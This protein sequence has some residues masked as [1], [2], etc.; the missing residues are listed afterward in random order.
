[1]DT[2]KKPRFQ[3]LAADLLETHMT[4]RRIPPDYSS[5]E[6]PLS[7]SVP[8]GKDVTIRAPE[9]GLPQGDGA[10]LQILKSMG[11]GPG[12]VGGGSVTVTHCPEKL[13]GGG[14]LICPMRRTCSHPSPSWP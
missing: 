3:G 1:M 10:F 4:P 5:L 2:W 11:V 7:T 6:L 12:D 14:P 13:D 9:S 8:V